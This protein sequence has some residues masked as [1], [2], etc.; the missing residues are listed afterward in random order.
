MGSCDELLAFLKKN[1]SAKAKLKE[2]VNWALASLSGKKYRMIMIYKYTI[3]A[4]AH[5]R[6]S[7]WVGLSSL[8]NN[9]K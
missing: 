6:E 3:K 7:L 9:I 4:S 5:A 2:E 1:P 8:M